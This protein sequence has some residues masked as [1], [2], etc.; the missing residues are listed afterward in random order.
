MNYLILNLHFY[1][2]FKVMWICIIV[3]HLILNFFLELFMWVNDVHISDFIGIFYFVM[4][5]IYYETTQ[6]RNTNI[7]DMKLLP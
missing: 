2:P 6:N 4:T 7:N 5:M 1:G 3:D